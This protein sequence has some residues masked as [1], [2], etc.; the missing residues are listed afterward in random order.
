MDADLR[1]AFSTLSAQLADVNAN[2][3]TA[4]DRALEAS[5]G[6]RRLE[7]RVEKLEKHVFGSDPPSTPPHGSALV[8]Q[9]SEHESEIAMLT[10]HVVAVDAKVAKLTEMQERQ[11]EL[12]ETIT[13]AVG[14]ILGHPMVRRIGTLA[15]AIVLAWL[16]AKTQGLV[17]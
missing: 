9:V 12:L 13:K 1:E 7:G 5:L 10:G 2:A 8:R 14:G 11:T 15:G 17:K 3:R 16:T 4:A 6:V